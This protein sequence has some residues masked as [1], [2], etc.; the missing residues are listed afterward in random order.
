MGI[1]DRPPFLG[2]FLSFCAKKS[3]PESN[4]FFASLVC[5][6]SACRLSARPSVLRIMGEINGEGGSGLMMV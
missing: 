5:Y 6:A 3:A 2:G 1:H 4:L